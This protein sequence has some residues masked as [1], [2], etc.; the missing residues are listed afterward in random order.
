MKKLLALPV[1]LSFSGALAQTFPAKAFTVIV[2]LMLMATQDSPFKSS[3]EMAT[4]LLGERVNR[5][6][7]SPDR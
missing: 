2:P 7:F 3:G 1:S 4:A 5:H 6:P